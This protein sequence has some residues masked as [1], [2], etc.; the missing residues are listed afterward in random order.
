[1]ST[2]GSVHD[3]EEFE[4]A[5]G[6]GGR[7]Q[8]LHDAGNEGK[9]NRRSKLARLPRP[10]SSFVKPLDNNVA[11]APPGAP[12]SC[13]ALATHPPGVRAASAAHADV[14][15]SFGKPLKPMGVFEADWTA[16]GQAE[17]D[18]ACAREIMARERPTTAQW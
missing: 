8:L 16:S 10:K 11:A 15:V 9:H 6:G 17:K 12:P 3:D 7:L 14:V 13:F 1:M 2:C 18:I 5:A 4:G